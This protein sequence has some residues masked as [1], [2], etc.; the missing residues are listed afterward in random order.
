MDEFK[1]YVIENWPTI[2]EYA[3]MG[4]GYFLVF[5]YRSKVSGTKRDLTVLFKEKAQEIGTLFQEKTK[6]VV[7]TDFKL[8]EDVNTA[9]KIM[10]TELAEA[11]AQYEAA[12]AKIS[13]LESKLFQVE[14]ALMA[15]IDEA[16]D[17]DNTEVDD[18]KQT[19]D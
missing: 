12:V 15:I 4:I 11:K 10:D 19:A 1:Q 17:I 6:E 9:R 5:L 2:I 16:D 18:G 14:G 8:R 13:G 7:D 3:L